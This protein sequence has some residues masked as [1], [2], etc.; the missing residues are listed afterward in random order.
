MDGRQ[1]L[2]GLL[3]ASL[4]GDV[5]PP[6]RPRCLR[7]RLD[8][9]DVLR[10]QSNCGGMR[11]VRCRGVTARGRSMSRRW[12]PWRSRKGKPMRVFLAGGSGVIGQQMVPMLVA[13]D[14]EVVAS[15]RLSVSPPWVP[16][17]SAWT[18][19]RHGR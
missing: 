5:G 7:T 16:V 13:E 8:V 17:S 9:G 10:E 11:V 14:H 19:G 12:E 4:H 2:V 15:A 1:Q 6:H 3:A 18:R